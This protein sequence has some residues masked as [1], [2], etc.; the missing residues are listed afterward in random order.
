[1][2]LLSCS[3]E[4]EGQKDR[5]R[6]EQVSSQISRVAVVKVMISYCSRNIINGDNGESSGAC[7]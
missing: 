6:R 4:T 2:K 3:S 1:M 7:C 5:V